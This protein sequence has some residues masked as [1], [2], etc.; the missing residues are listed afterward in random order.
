[1]ASLL[2]SGN[3]TF[4]VGAKQAAAI[5]IGAMDGCTNPC[6][7]YS[8]QV[9]EPVYPRHS[10]CVGN[11][12]PDGQSDHTFG[13]LI[14]TFTGAGDT[15]GAQRFKFDVYGNWTENH[16][17][18]GADGVLDQASTSDILFSGVGKYHVKVSE[19]TDTR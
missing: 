18:T 10:E 16:G 14:V 7:L 19:K 11:H 15:T 1:M 6:R 4:T 13:L 12:R 5:H 17:D 9:P 8:T 2:S 3:A